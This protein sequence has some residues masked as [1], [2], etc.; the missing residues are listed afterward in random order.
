MYELLSLEQ[1]A[2]I[3]LERIVGEHDGVKQAVLEHIGNADIN[4]V[5]TKQLLYLLQVYTGTANNNGEQ[6]AN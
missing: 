1:V 3:T 6:N 2:R 4:E 5:G